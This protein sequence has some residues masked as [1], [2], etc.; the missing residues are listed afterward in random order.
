MSLTTVSKELS[1]REL[2]IQAAASA[3]LC[4]FAHAYD[5][6]DD[7][8]DK[9]NAI[10]SKTCPTLTRFATMCDMSLVKQLAFIMPSSKMA[11]MSCPFSAIGRNNKE[12]FAGSLGDSMEIICPVTIKMSD[13]RGNV[14]SICKTRAEANVQNLPT[15]TSNP[16]KEDAPPSADKDNL[17]IVK[18]A[19]PDCIGIKLN[20]ATKE[21]CFVAIPKVL[22]IAGGITAFAE[23][24]STASIATTPTMPSIPPGSVTAVWYEARRYDICHLDNSSL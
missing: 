11:V 20:F 7:Q 12:V 24:S 4:S 9:V 18:V 8:V 17:K 2:A 21:P 15:S 22:S 5:C 1:F 13:A 10:F 14:L 23:L 6:N 19:G 3:K 16:L